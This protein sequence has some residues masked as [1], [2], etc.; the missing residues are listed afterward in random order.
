[1]EKPEKLLYTVK[2]AAAAL[3]VNTSTIYQLINKGLLPGL[4]LG[5]L[6]IRKASLEK[7]IKDYDGMDFSDLDNIIP[8]TSEHERGTK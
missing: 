5:C 7:F 8:Y 1:M 3:G 6:K 4:K 2:E